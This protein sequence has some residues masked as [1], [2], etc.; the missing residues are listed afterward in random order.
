MFGQ[1]GITNKD[2]ALCMWLKA[3][4][5]FVNLLPFISEELGCGLHAFTVFVWGQV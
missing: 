1:I 2:L 4:L 3:I 5:F